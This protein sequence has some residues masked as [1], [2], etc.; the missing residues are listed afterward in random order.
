[1]A[2]YSA[3][4][5][6]PL[7]SS[8][9]G[10]ALQQ[11]VGSFN[12][13]LVALELPALS[14]PPPLSTARVTADELEEL[15]SDAAVGINSI[16]LRDRIG[17]WELGDVEVQLAFRL[18]DLVRRDSVTLAPRFTYQLGGGV[19]A[20]LGTGREDDP[21]VFLDLAAGDGQTDI[22]GRVFSNLRTGRFGVWGDL[23]Y[24]LQ[25]PRTLV[26]RVG[27]PELVFVPAVNRATVEWTPGSY[28]ELE[29]Y[30]RYHFTSEL[31][32]TAGYRLR[33]KGEDDFV[34]LSP[35]PDP[36][37]PSPLPSPPLYTD[38]ALL[39]QDTKETVH[40]LGGGLVFST[41]EAWEAG[42]ASRP[43]ELRFNVSWAT[44]GA[45]RQAP[46]GVRAVVGLRLYYR[47][48]GD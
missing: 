31:A 24:G 28:L 22:E 43:F 11:R 5:F 15:L 42:R 12:E 21:D 33:A 41:L 36:A 23:R 14:S 17:L 48:W 4:P 3:S 2:S 30:P 10:Q 44:S 13:G 7:A 27:P 40:E 20:R 34:R 18:I 25:R 47:I 29:L 45:G 26:R 38:V 32:F 1:V 6:F 46:K 19:L 16:P 39:T 9:E 8:P 35:A 37:D